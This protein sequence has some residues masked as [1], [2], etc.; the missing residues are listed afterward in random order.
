MRTSSYTQETMVI[1][2]PSKSLVMLMNKL[3]DRKI[4]QLKELKEKKDFYFPKNKQ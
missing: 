1:E 4:A 2:N 3:R